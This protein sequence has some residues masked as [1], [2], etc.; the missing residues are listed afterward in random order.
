[1]E[2]YM[3]PCLNKKYLGF[4]CMGCGI[5]RSAAL[6]LKGEFIDAFY[7]YPGIY[8]LIALLGF[9]LVNQ[10]ITIKYANKT[11]IF[12]AILTVST[13]IVSYLIKILN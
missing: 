10:F 8:P 4:E 9:L 7:M 6:L 3:L 2:E 12:L 13:I 1:M 11:I 5:Q